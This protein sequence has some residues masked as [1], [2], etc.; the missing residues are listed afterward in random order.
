MRI[1]WSYGT[2]FPVRQRGGNRENE[3]SNCQR[4]DRIY[5]GI[6]SLLQVMKKEDIFLFEEQMEVDQ[7]LFLMT[8]TLV[9]R[10][11]VKALYPVN[12]LQLLYTMGAY[13]EISKGVLFCV[14]RRAVQKYRTDFVGRRMKNRSG[15][16]KNGI[17][18]SG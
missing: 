1:W 11:I 8:K 3:A 4:A 9:S 12:I 5:A 16:V 2:I 13:G 6:P 10:G 17:R 14:R 15:H 7:L 18:T